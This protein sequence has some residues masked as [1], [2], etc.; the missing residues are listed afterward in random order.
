MSF[1]KISLKYKH[2]EKEIL[3]WFCPAEYFLE[4]SDL[5]GLSDITVSSVH[6]SDLSSLEGESDDDQQQSDSSE[7]GELPP[8][9]I[10]IVP[11]LM[12]QKTCFSCGY[13]CTCSF[14]FLSQ[15]RMKKRRNPV[16]NIN[17]VA[18]P[19]FTNPSSTPVTIATQMMKSLWRNAVG[20]RWAVSL[21]SRFTVWKIPF[22]SKFIMLLDFFNHFIGMFWLALSAM[23]GG[24]S[25]KGQRGEASKETKEQRAN[26]RAAQTE[27]RVDW[28][29]RYFSQRRDTMH[30][31]DCPTQIWT[32]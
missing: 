11:F 6:T 17:L 7:E 5:E 19:M 23:T 27:I 9:G 3:K 1:A 15:I 28:R 16:K 14:F 2:I 21:D 13:T 20:L 30:N 26:G 8:D 24:L 29:P 18:K 25:G 12:G 4:D 31:A 10:N 32:K 22:C